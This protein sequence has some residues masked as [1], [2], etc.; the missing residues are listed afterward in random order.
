MPAPRRASA[1]AAA[2]AAAHKVLV[3]YVPSAQTTLDAAYAASLAKLPDGKAKSRGITYGSRVA[4]NLIR[5]RADDG[6]NA[7]HPVHPTRRPRGVAAHPAGVR[8]DGRP[9]DGLCDAAAGPQSHPVR[10]TAS[11]GAHLQALHP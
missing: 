10:P 5:L 8:A 2:V 9:L 1:Q 4:D 3:T 11:A 6:R 7:P